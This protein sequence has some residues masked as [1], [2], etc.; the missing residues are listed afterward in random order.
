M[1]GMVEHQLV[2]LLKDVAKNDNKGY[3]TLHTMSMLLNDCVKHDTQF[4]KYVDPLSLFDFI[5][6]TQPF[7]FDTLP[8]NKTL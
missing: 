3:P 1:F 5:Q 8:I 4:V 7:L 2:H 6:V